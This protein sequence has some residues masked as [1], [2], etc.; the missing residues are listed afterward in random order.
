MNRSPARLL[1]VVFGAF[2]A[3]AFSQEVN[4]RLLVGLSAGTVTPVS[5]GYFGHYWNMGPS[6]AIDFSVGFAPRGEFVASLSA[7]R[8]GYGA[9]GLPVLVTGSP[10]SVQQLAGGE[11]TFLEATIGLRVLAA[12]GGAA[13]YVEIGA[14]L[15]RVRV[16]AF[17]AHPPGVLA[18]PIIVSG[19][20]VSERATF[21]GGIGERFPISDT[22]SGFLVVEARVT[23]TN[24]DLLVRSPLK[25]GVSFM[26]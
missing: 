25:L 10:Y 21:Y 1:T 8:V 26:P 12:A 4:A 19:E 6:A 22:L 17:G 3:M 7:E 23:T 9:E 18:E 13:P 11:V 20:T 14:G 2:V 5:P 15:S 24:G 16:G